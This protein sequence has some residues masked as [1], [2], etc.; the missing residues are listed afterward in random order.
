MIKSKS[1]E[2]YIHIPFCVQKCKYCDFLSAP[3]DETVKE[4][5]MKALCREIIEKSRDYQAYVVTTVFIGG[6]TPTAVPAVWIKHVMESVRQHYNLLEEAEITMEM[7]PGTVEPDAWQTYRKAGINR[8]SIGLQSTEAAELRVLGRIHS[9]EQFLETYRLA[10]SC[11]FENIN[12]DIMSA[13][14][15]QTR[16]SYQRTLE[17]VTGLVPPPEHISAY[18]LIVE[19]GT[20]FYE[21]YEAGRLDLPDEDTERSMYELTGSFLHERG[22]ERYEISNYAK[23][24]KECRHNLGYWERVNYL[25]FGIGAASLIENVRFQNGR[26]LESYLQAPCEATEEY[27]HLSVAEQ[28]E[29]TMFLGLRKTAGV[30][31]EAFEETFDVSFGQVYG[32]VAEKHIQEGL[33]ER[34]PDSSGRQYLALT[35]KGMDVSNYVMADF[36]EPNAL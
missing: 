22:Y 15:G 26:D 25:G 28:M 18:S 33:L 5:Y 10:R 24:G 29:E 11:G 12:V 17:R 23:P 1:L 2:L 7:N 21:A 30:D 6:G 32:E 13:L 4:A 3:A 31:L 34:K 27:Q 14:P 19:E 8:L 35:A 36:L 20:P 9:Y 16:E